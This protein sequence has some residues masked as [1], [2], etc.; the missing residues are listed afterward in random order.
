MNN[1]IGR[2]N[3]QI[4]ACYAF[5]FHS[6]MANLRLSNLDSSTELKSSD[7]LS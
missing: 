5:T 1:R 4:I 3:M 6:L 2:Y 7:S